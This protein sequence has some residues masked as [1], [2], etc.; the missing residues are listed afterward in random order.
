MTPRN[1]AY[2][3]VETASLEMKNRLE[4][5]GRLPV[6]GGGCAGAPFSAK[7]NHVGKLSRRINRLVERPTLHSLIAT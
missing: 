5:G 4:S 7:R 3:P 1:T 2:R 6:G